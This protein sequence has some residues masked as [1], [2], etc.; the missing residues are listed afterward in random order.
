MGR[1][2]RRYP[3]YRCYSNG[4]LITRFESAFSCKLIYVFSIAD[5]A[6]KGHLKIDLATVKP[7]LSSLPDIEVYY[8]ADKVRYVVYVNRFEIKKNT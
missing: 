1:Q 4:V 7:D 2:T 3:P 8:I 6:H 5:E